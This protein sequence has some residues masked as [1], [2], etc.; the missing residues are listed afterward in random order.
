MLF[1][2]V[3]TQ[4]IVIVDTTDFFWT[5]LDLLFYTD[6]NRGP[7]STPYAELQNTYQVDFLAPVL[8]KQQMFGHS[9]LYSHT[10][11]QLQDL[12]RAN[13]RQF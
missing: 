8:T 11:Q 3:Y 6:Q 12:C 2:S 4:I 10:M 5:G 7:M 9:R 13:L 1:D